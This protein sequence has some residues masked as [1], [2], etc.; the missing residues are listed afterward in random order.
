[1]FAKARLSISPALNAVDAAGLR[2]FL[3]TRNLTERKLP[4][5]LWHSVVHEFTH[6]WEFFGP[7]GTALN[8]LY[9]RQCQRIIE[10]TNED[11]PVEELLEYTQNALFVN[12]VVL[13]CLKPIAEGIA[14]FAEHDLTPSSA[15]VEST[16]LQWS[17]ILFTDS[18]G[19][20]GM[21]EQEIVRLLD[22]R[23]MSFLGAVRLSVQAVDR[24][25]DLLAEAF[26]EVGQDDTPEEDWECY[27]G[28]YLYI[29][30]LQRAKI[31]ADSRAL[32]G[33]L[34]ILLLQ[35]LIFY[36]Y[37]LVNVLLE[38]LD[39]GQD[40]IE[41]ASRITGVISYRLRELLIGD[42][43][44]MLDEVTKR[45]LGTSESS[46]LQP[47]PLPSGVQSYTLDDGTTV[48]ARWTRGIRRLSHET[49]M[50]LNGSEYMA[51]M[52][53]L[54]LSQREVFVLFRSDFDCATRNGFVVAVTDD[55]IEY[56]V[57]TAELVGLE[58]D[59]ASARGRFEILI[60]PGRGQLVAIHYIDDKLVRYSTLRNVGGIAEDPDVKRAVEMRAD[61]IKAQQNLASTWRNLGEL[62]GRTVDGLTLKIAAT[63]I[64]RD[65]YQSNI[66]RIGLG[67]L[68]QGS[69]P[70][71]I[72]TPE[73]IRQAD[74]VRVMG[75]F[76]D[77]VGPGNLRKLAA[78]SLI[79]P[80]S[81][82]RSDVKELFRAM[83][84]EYDM[85][86]DLDSFESTMFQ[87]EANV[88]ARGVLDWLA[89]TLLLPWI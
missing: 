56:P 67:M 32:S 61:A 48:S 85:D 30:S 34:L 79:P 45:G 88:L 87:S 9:L 57:V 6:H 80:F 14:L 52:G 10:A 49:S 37:A 5:H 74:A 63:E 73:A 78:L 43:S 3:R 44:A 1:M 15:P 7:V 64:A 54:C 83:G 71:A 12:D 29:K 33:C 65:F 59:G 19:L 26:D 51:E 18:T 8:I 4:E 24:K 20:K 38:A 66:L 40:H 39:P 42:L 47:L 28:G 68:I 75:S 86:W 58:E 35:S 13:A 72:D 41:I 55:P 53:R 46:S 21:P 60:F 69:S 82:S 50:I 23:M 16:V 2:E 36:D 81:A 77:I 76:L 17:R 70:E 11:R 25:A 22:E 84:E 89:D 31:A 27:L 62:T